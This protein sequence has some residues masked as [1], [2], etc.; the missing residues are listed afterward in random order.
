MVNLFYVLFLQTGLFI[1]LMDTHTQKE[2]FR[3]WSKKIINNL[4]SDA[5]INPKDDICFGF[6]NRLELLQLFGM[7]VLASLPVR[8]SVLDQSTYTKYLQV[9]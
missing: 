6:A 8:L 4:G 2:G 9:L 7:A 5:L 1:L 3:H